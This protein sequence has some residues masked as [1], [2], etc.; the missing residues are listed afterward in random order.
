MVP[1]DVSLPVCDGQRRLGRLTRRADYQA[2]ACTKRKAVMPGMVVQVRSHDDA[3]RTATAAPVRVGFTASR[4]VGNA[5]ARNR[6]RR[7]LR[8]LAAEILGQRVDSG[9]D[10]VLIARQETVARPFVD[11]RSDLLRALRRLG[12]LR[13]GPK[14]EDRP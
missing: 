10:L 5:V 13:P 4:K 8:A 12:V 1:D 9:H 7:R 2:V 14:P 11:L 6:A 3:D